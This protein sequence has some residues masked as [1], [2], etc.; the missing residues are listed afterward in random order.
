V[1]WLHAAWERR[2][3]TAGDRF[4][5]HPAYRHRTEDF[6][7]QYSEA[8]LY[9]YL[10]I[11]P[12]AWQPLEA[13]ARALG[14]DLDSAML[15]TFAPARGEANFYIIDFPFAKKIDQDMPYRIFYY[16]YRVSHLFGRDFKEP[17]IGLCRDMKQTHRNSPIVIFSSRT[18]DSQLLVKYTVNVSTTTW[19]PVT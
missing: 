7:Q 18:I 17:V 10:H 1:E 11:L 6:A 19:L 15:E 4:Q 3:I 13:L 14:M 12:C 8:V 16:A 5:R 2:V 9:R